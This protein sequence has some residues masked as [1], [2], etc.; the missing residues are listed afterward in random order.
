RSFRLC[1]RAPRMEI[2]S[3]GMACVG[4]WAGEGSGFRV[5]DGPEIENWPLQIEKCKLGRTP[6]RAAPRSK[7]CR[8]RGRLA[9]GD[10]SNLCLPAR[11][12]YHES[13][14]GVGYWVLGIGYWVLGIGCWGFGVRGS[15]G[16]AAHRTVPFQ[17]IS[18]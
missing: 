5:R 4:R 10:A 14:V 2:L 6:R 13:G 7:S 17:S 8:G 3:R 18:H 9:A 11:T 16:M 12:F 15:D 1:W